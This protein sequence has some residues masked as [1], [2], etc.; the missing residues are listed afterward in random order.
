MM[1]SQP[2]SVS[3]IIPSYNEEASLPHLYEALKELM[4][5]ISAYDWEVLFVNDGSK[6]ATLPMINALYE[7]DSRISYVDLSRNFGK[8]K[9]MLAG[10]DYCRGD[11]AVIIDADLQDPPYLIKDMLKYW[12]EGYE[13]VYAKRRNRGKEPW[14]RRKLSMMFYN[15]LDRSTRFEVLK[16]VGDFRL[17]DR[18]CIEALRQLRE[19]ERYT[20]GLFC[21]IGYKKKEILFDRDDRKY[22]QTHWN[23]WQLAGLAIEGF[24]SFTTAPLRFATVIGSLTAFGAIIYLIWTLIKVA[25]WGDP[26]AGFPTLISVVLFLGAVQ[27]IAI[28]ILGEYIGR[29]FNESKNR[30]VYLVE[31]YKSRNID[32]AQK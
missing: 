4:D 8:E 9:A 5:S 19:S 30:P 18:K 7:K 32:E 31:T 1:N 3:I 13:D 17:L 12:E 22:G 21:W 6:D 29:I 23:F 28:G 14:L 10:F 15:M 27:L 24:T 11:C 20:K 2:K 16:N 25:L 26:V